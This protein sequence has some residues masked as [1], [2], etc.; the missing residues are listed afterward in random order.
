MI[1]EK[2]K[3][4]TINEAARNQILAAAAAAAAK[5]WRI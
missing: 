4:N 5:D 2:V 3:Q 1:G